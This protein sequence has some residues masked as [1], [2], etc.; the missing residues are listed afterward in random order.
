MGRSRTLKRR[1]GRAGQRI[2]RAAPFLV[3]GFACLLYLNTLGHGFVFDDVT[4]I[5]QNPQ[6]TQL[7]WGEILGFGSYR[8]VRTFTYA[9]NFWWGGPDPFGFHLFNVLLHGFNGVLVFSLFRRLRCPA[10]WSLAGALVFVAHPA[11]TAAVAYISGRKDMLATGFILIGL[12]AYLTFRRTRRFPY[13]GMVVAAFGLAVLSKEVALVFPVLLLL[14]ELCRRRQAVIHPLEALR[15]SFRNLWWLYLSMIAMAAA[16]LYYSVEVLQASRM[17]GLWGGSWTTNL[18]TSFKLFLHY[19]RLVLVPYPL[20]ADY[21]GDVFSVSNGFLEP[22]TL[23]ATLMTVAYGGVAAWMFSRRPRLT[24]GMLWF[25]VSL[26][27][28][29]QLIPFHELAADHFLYLPLIGPAFLAGFAVNRLASRLPRT[30]WAWAVL[31]VWLAVAAIMTVDR[32]RDWKDNQTLWSATYRKAPGSFRANCNLGGLA[33]DRREW[34]LALTFTRRCLELDPQEALPHANLGAIYRDLGNRALQAGRFGVAEDH[35][36]QAIEYSRKALALEEDN[37]WARSNLADAFKDLALLAERRGESRAKVSELRRRAIRHF[38]EAIRQ[39]EG[40]DAQAAVIFKL[41]AVQLD[42]GNYREALRYFLQC[43]DELA[44]WAQPQAATGYAY[45]QLGLY[46]ESIPYFQR[47]LQLEPSLD[48]F[49]G[50]ARAQEALNDPQAAIGTLE[51]ALVRFPREG[52]VLYELGRL[53]FVTDDRRSA[54]VY[55]LRALQASPPTE[56]AAASRKLLRTL[57]DLG[58]GRDPGA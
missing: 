14:T 47:A 4:L 13:L 50:L 10:A 6:V 42:A 57:E 43:V 56:V 12:L 19:L 55:L 28:V 52:E 9:A 34:E 53:H 17:D 25:L 24:F 15:A 36:R 37:P 35:L 39:A 31:A 33:Q 49:F 54:R 48:A 16:G 3:F 22:A 1:S 45:L 40:Y 18:G 44:H 38:Q 41:G 26:L 46:Q 5:L 20:L 29:L 2:V 21:L 11:Q 27:P 51:A 32:N 23:F 7:K 58:S 8:P 30:E